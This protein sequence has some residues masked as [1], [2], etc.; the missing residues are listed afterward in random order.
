MWW[1]RFLLGFTG[2][3][4]LWMYHVKEPNKVAASDASLKGLGA[5]CGKIY[6]KL[7]FTRELQNTNIAHLELMAIVVMVK[8]WLN[9]FTGKSV[10]FKCDN[11]AVVSVVNK[12]R[13]KDPRLLELLRELVFVAATRFEFHAVH[14]SGQKNILPDLLS[15][16]WEGRR[17][18]EK[19]SK[20][21]NG[22]GYQ[23]VECT[24]ELFTIT[25]NW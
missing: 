19:F 25:H 23:E 2:Q 14:L 18:Q 9:E 11:E 21:T 17:T 3:C 4:V 24:P 15:R 20:L 8:V 10:V 16:W 5:V 1:Q 12:G 13:A 6:I 22:K 7:K